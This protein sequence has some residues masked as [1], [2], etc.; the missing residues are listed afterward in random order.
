M[1]CSL[2]LLLL[3][4]CTLAPARVIA[5]VSRAEHVVIVG[6]DGLSPDGVRRAKTPNLGRMMKEGAYT[7]HA[8]GVMPTVSSPNWASMI[9]GAGP[10][11]ARRHVERMGAAPR[12]TSRRRPWG[13]EGIFPTIF[14][15]LRAQRPPAKIAGLPRLGR[16]RAAVRA[17]SRRPDRGQRRAGQGGRARRRLYQEGAAPVHLHPPRPR[18]ST[19]GT[20]TATGRPSITRPSR[21]PTA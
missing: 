13:P 15:V 1:R 20:P 18:R 8:R 10:G 17:Q 3:L 9:M 11:A 2:S 21:K 14:G 12:P 7:L 4:G 19:R 16:F 6:V 5:Q